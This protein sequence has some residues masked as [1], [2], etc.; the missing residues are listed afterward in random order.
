MKRLTWIIG[1]ASSP[2]AR[3]GTGSEKM[4]FG[5]HDG[6]GH[7]LATDLT[8]DDGWVRYLSH[9]LLFPEYPVHVSMSMM[10]FMLLF[11]PKDDEAAGLCTS[12]VARPTRSGQ[13][14]GP[15][16]SAERVRQELS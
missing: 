2:W 9:D 1:L 5:S 12:S 13:D 11:D 7:V 8:I 14:R 3:E 15:S 6:R 10:A 4:I 16:A